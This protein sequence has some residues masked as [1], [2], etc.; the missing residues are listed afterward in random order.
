MERREAI[1][2]IAAASIALPAMANNIQKKDKTMKIELPKL[3]Y[4]N[5][6]LT[7]IISAE[8]IEY[9]YGKHH[10]AYVTNLN[11]LIEGG[12]HEKKSLEEIIKSST[13]PVFNNAA[14]VW[15]HSFY[16]NCLTPNKST[17][18]SK[19]LA[20]AIDK[21]FGSKAQ[22]IEHF[23]KSAVGNFGSGWTWLVKNQDS[24]LEIINTSN[25]ATPLTQGKKAILTVD[26]WEH[27]YYVDYRNL[28]AKYCEKIWEIINWDFASKNFAS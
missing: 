11:N 6:A 26:V 17:Q 23:N 13:G 24:S 7:P 9:H 2:I 27:A 5:D 14:Q 25:A 16:W 21:Q 15:N 3:P 18:P 10:A 1:S 8:T 20:D 22:F 19:E 12:E 4:A 28:R